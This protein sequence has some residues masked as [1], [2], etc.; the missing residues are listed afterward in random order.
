MWQEQGWGWR[1]GQGQGYRQGQIEDITGNKKK[2]KDDCG[3]LNKN[4]LSYCCLGVGCMCVG[5]GLQRYRA[6]LSEGL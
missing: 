2:I 5:G 1:L 3:D 6:F 4:G